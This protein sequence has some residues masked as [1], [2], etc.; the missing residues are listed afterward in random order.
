MANN[1]GKISQVIGPVIDIVFENS[2]SGLPKIYDALE[3]KNKIATSSSRGNCTTQC[4]RPHEIRLDVVDT[5]I[6]FIN[7]HGRN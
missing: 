2:D 5:P 1:I 4:G 3:V 6:G 7:L